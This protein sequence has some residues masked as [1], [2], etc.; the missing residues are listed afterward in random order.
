M[1]DHKEICKKVGFMGTRNRM[2]AGED[3]FLYAKSNGYTEEYRHFFYSDIQSI[4]IFK[5]SWQTINGII[6]GILLFLVMVGIGI[7]LWF[8]FE[9]SKNSDEAFTLTVLVL[10]AILF[11]LF[12]TPFIVNIVKGPTAKAVIRTLSSEDAVVLTGRLRSSI[13]I[14]DKMRPYIESVQGDF[15]KKKWTRIKQSRAGFDEA[16]QSKSHPTSY[17]IRVT[18]ACSKRSS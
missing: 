15:D 4:D 6:L 18:R 12:L 14:I 5:T 10:L 9:V 11:I 17:R 7:A 13:K 2:L 16:S 3:H 1:Q 8:T